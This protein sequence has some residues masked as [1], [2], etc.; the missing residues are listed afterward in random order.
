MSQR[1]RAFNIPPVVLVLAVAL[2]AIHAARQLVSPAT[3]EWLL[4]TFSFIPARYGE[5]FAVLPGGYGALFW[6]PLTYSLLHADWVHLTV[7]LVWMASFGS[8]LAR[9]F[10][11]IRFL[12]FCAITAIA[13]AGAHTLAYP[14]DESIVIGAS[15]AVSGVTAAAAR[16]AFTSAGPL[17]TSL[18][19][20]DAYLAPAL[21]LV[22][23]LRDGRSMTFIILWFAM[24]FVF[25]ISGFMAPG[26]EGTIAWQA[27][28]GG[29]LAG[30]I[31]FSFLD[32]VRRA[33]STQ[34]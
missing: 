21:T 33:M 19:R 6:T 8:A 11:S 15:A 28:V 3:D 27:H 32:P 1:E 5:A 18:G 13:G 29:F 17:G 23:T 25:G 7:N 10:G 34:A 30:L 14:G 31:A 16:F 9:R 24:N 12:L 26:V 2:G 20:E 22:G 4:L